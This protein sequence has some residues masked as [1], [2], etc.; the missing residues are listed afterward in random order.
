MDQEFID[1]V[2]LHWEHG[3]V[4]RIR[5][6][7]QALGANALVPAWRRT[8]KDLKAPR[9]YVIGDKVRTR[10]K[11]KITLTI[12]R[13]GQKIE[14]GLLDLPISIEFAKDSWEP[15]APPYLATD[16][17]PVQVVEAETFADLQNF[18]DGH[19]L[20]EFPN[21]RFFADD[22]KRRMDP[23]SVDASRFIH[24]FSN[25]ESHVI[26]NIE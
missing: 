6:L 20:V 24:W 2:V 4:R 23:V 14:P 21:M 18:I 5:P 1:Q 17:G 12:G 13:A 3:F 26:E 16:Q 8:G 22:L 19:R 10:Y 9:I 7:L 11:R 15:D 25:A